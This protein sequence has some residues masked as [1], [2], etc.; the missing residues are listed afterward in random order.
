M[1]TF[2]H[3]VNIGEPAKYLM[4]AFSRTPG[5]ERTLRNPALEQVL[6]C[7]K[8]VGRGKGAPR[9]AR[10]RE[11]AIANAEGGEER[12]PA[13][14]PGGLLCPPLFIKHLLCERCWGSQ[15]PRLV[16]LPFQQARRE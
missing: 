11:D 13:A 3:A 15:I 6:R 12:A 5:T 16:K 4:A 2:W 8:P 10:S 9:P 7:G 1:F 14:Q